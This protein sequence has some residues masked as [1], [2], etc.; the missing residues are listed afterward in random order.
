MTKLKA[1]FDRYLEKFKQLQEEYDEYTGIDQTKADEKL[2]LMKN[3]IEQ[4]EIK[5]S[6]N[7]ILN[8]IEKHEKIA[9]SDENR[10]FAE[11]K[12]TVQSLKQEIEIARVKQDIELQDLKKQED[13]LEL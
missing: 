6:D 2:R 13:Y 3:K 5:L 1:T 12:V 8:V 9:Q 10:N 7:E 4:Y 11:F